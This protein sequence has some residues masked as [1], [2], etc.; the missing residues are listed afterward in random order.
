MG[1]RSQLQKKKIGQKTTIV[2]LITYEAL[3]RGGEAIYCSDMSLTSPSMDESSNSKH[4]PRLHRIFLEAPIF[5][6]TTCVAHRRPL[7]AQADVVAIL[8]EEWRTAIKRHAWAVGRY[9]VM[10]D[11]VHFFCRPQ[12]QAKP[13]SAFMESWKS[14]SA[15]SI[16]RTLGRPSPLWQPEFFDHLVRSETSYL[17]KWDYVRHNPIRAGLASDLAEWPWQGFIQDLEWGV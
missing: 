17:E 14:W 16:L 12:P 2:F 15:R 3:A 1:R 5:F 4:L 9:V 6:V 11:H 7:L 8:I 10:P 13:L